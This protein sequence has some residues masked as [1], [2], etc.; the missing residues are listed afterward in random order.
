MNASYDRL[1]LEKIT[2]YYTSLRY[3]LIPNIYCPKKMFTNK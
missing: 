3:L 1:T 2:N